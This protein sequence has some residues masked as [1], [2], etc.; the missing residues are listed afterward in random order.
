MVICQK[1]K[2]IDQEYGR[3]Q[4]LV[5]DKSIDINFPVVLTKFT[6]LLALCRYSKSSYLMRFIKMFLARGDVNLPLRY[7]AGIIRMV[8][9]CA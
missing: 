8:I 9:L 2:L 4:E 3:F 7:Y 5:L 6:P 1:E